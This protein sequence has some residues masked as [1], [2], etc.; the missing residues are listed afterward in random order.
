MKSVDPT[1]FGLVKARS[2]VTKPGRYFTRNEK[3]RLIVAERERKAR[4]AEG[5]AMLNEAKASLRAEAAN[6]AR[7]Q[8]AVMKKRQLGIAP[9]VPIQEDAKG[10]LFCQERVKGRFGKRIV[11]G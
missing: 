11:L 8:A 3:I 5:L 1:R 9:T 6:K 7:M 4:R 2:G 10:N